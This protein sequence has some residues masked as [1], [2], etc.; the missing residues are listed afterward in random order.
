MDCDASSAIR[1][2]LTEVS[3]EQEGI[4]NIDLELGVAEMIRDKFVGGDSGQIE[5]N[6]QEGG[7]SGVEEAE[8]ALEAGNVITER[9]IG[10][11]RLVHLHRFKFRIFVFF[12]LDRLLYSGSKFR[13]SCRKSAREGPSARIAVNEE[14]AI[15][16]ALSQAAR[17]RG[18][19]IF[20]PLEGTLFSSSEEARDFFNLYSWE[21]GFGIRYGRSNKNNKGYTTR[22]DIVCSCEVSVD[23]ALFFSLSF[24]FPSCCWCYIIVNHSL[25]VSKS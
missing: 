24:I 21:I 25:Y 23:S 19:P 18:S 13:W 3:P 8:L 2:C 11:T 17:N 16:R 4:M 6:G 10:W 14:S 22:Q 20:Q 15:T 7:D 9:R 5:G 1:R 12:L